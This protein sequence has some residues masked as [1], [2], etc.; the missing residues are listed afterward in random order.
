MCV[1]ALAFFLA[2]CSGVKLESVEGKVLVDGQPLP[3]GSFQ[4]K[5]DVSK[6][7]KSTLEPVGLVE[8]P[9]VYKIYTEKKPG[10]PAGWYKVVVVAQEPIDPND[11]YKERKSF[12]NGKY[13]SAQ[14]TDLTIE[15]TSAP[16]PGAYD[17]NMKK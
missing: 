8:S 1:F 9:G 3:H 7:N 13:N 10:A 6:G 17:L 5:P 14:T 2:G 12:I 4:F 16:A 11:L 15:I